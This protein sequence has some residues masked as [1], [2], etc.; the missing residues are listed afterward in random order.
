MTNAVV[1]K[2]CSYCSKITSISFTG[3]VNTR[4]IIAPWESCTVLL[5]ASVCRPCSVC[6]SVLCV[7]Q[8]LVPT[9]TRSRLGHMRYLLCTFVSSGLQ[10]LKYG[11]WFLMSL[12][13]HAVINL[14][15]FTMH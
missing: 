1:P 6:G 13:I 7:V 14:Q 10:L 2:V 8:L 9:W 4:D 3:K 12:C 11:H 15:L 5:C